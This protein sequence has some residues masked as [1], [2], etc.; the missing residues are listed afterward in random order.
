MDEDMYLQTGWGRK[1]AFSPHPIS[2]PLV[3]DVLFQL[4]GFRGAWPG[5]YNPRLR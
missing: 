2:S 1:K 5:I 3:V 4:I